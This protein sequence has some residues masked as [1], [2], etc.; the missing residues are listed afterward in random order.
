MNAYDVFLEVGIISQSGLAATAVPDVNDLDRFAGLMNPVIN[1]VRGVKDL[2]C[3]GAIADAGA[4]EGKGTQKFDMVEQIVTKALGYGRK[5]GPAVFEDDLE[6]GYRLLGESNL[7]IH[8][9]II[10]R[11]SSI[12]TVRPSSAAWTPRSM[13]ARVSSSSSSVRGI[14][15]FRSSVVSLTPPSCPL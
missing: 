9:G 5:I 14:E 8:S 3:V 4:H 2:V 7:E 13:A 12:G 10:F 6:I 1:R 11:T 15:W